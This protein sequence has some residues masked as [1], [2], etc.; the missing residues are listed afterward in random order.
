MRCIM[1][2]IMLYPFETCALAMFGVHPVIGELWELAKKTQKHPEGMH[3]NR[4]SYE[5]S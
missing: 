4:G 2:C 3:T 1:G 5:I